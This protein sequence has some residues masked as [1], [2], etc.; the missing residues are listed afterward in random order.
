MKKILVLISFVTLSF[1]VFGQDHVLPE[2]KDWGVEVFPIPIEFAPHIPFK[3]QEELRFSPGWG[4][5][6]SV[7][8]WSYCFIWWVDKDSKLDAKSLKAYLEEYYGGLVS[9]NITSRKIPKSKIVPTVAQ[10]QAGSGS[11]F[12]ATVSMLNYMRQKP[13]RLNIEV[14]VK[15][16]DTNG[17]KAFFFA[18]SPQ[19]KSHAIWADMRDF[20]K[21]FKCGS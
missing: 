3:G 21:G 13:M 16:C 6:T 17:K 19:Q 10:V 5:T 18:V 8:H 12:S 11:S 15:V 14:S 4:D 7:Q 1:S 2:R 9:R 20:W